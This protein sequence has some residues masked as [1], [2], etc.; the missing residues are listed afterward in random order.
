MWALT[1]V[2]P[3]VK[4]W[5]HVELWIY[6]IVS[7]EFFMLKGYITMLS[8]SLHLQNWLSITSVYPTALMVSVKLIYLWGFDP[9]SEWNFP[10]G[11][12]PL[13]GDRDEPYDSCTSR[14]RKVMLARTKTRK[15]ILTVTGDTFKVP[16]L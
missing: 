12:K 5:I 11:W 1:E 8:L 4:A 2:F 14:M 3:A 13:E 7:V 9:F 6:S 16:G 15:G 10:L